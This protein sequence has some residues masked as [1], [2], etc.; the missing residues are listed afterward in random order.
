MDSTSA[1]DKGGDAQGQ[2]SL[3]LF[4]SVLFEVSAD[5]LGQ[6]PGA[7]EWAIV[8]YRLSVYLTRQVN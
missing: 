4:I 8:S 7:Y 3:V 5:A 1:W 6:T 2:S